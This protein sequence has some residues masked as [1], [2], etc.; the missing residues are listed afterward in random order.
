MEQSVENVEIIVVDSGS[1]DATLSIASRFPV[2]IIHIKPDDF[3]FGRSLNLGCAAAAG[4]F[5]V[6]ASAH[7]YPVYTDWL[8][9]LLDPLNVP[10]IALSYGKQIGGPMTKFSEQRQFERMYPDESRIPQDFPLCN[11][12]NASVRRSLWEQHPYDESLSGLEDL[13]WASWALSEG[14]LL[15][16][17]ADAVIVHIHEETPSQVF[18]RYQREAIALTRIRPEEKFTLLDLVRL[19]STNVLD[20]LREALAHRNLLRVFTSI[21]WYRWMQFWGT[22]RGFQHSE[23]VTD[24][25][26]R[27]FYYPSNRIGRKTKMDRAREAINYSGSTWVEAELDSNDG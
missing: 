21:F 11:N 13:E 12:A 3:T 25:V 19:F 17:N 4:E 5:L 27:A 20:D 24:E 9:E 18:K 14:Y 1:T 22:Y 26:I 2:Q 15:A 23:P 16:Y 7:V 8:E 10:Q 6:F